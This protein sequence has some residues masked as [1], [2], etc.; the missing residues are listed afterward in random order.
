MP[1]DK[2]HRDAERKVA[3]TTLAGTAV[4]A[5]VGGLG[6]LTPMGALAGAVKGMAYAESASIGAECGY[7][8]LFPEDKEE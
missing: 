5:L 7:C 3:G 4:G 6:T 2:I 1:D 8:H